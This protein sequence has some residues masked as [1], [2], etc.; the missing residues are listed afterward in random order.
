MSWDLFSELFL[1]GFFILFDANLRSKQ[2]ILLASH[3]HLVPTTFSA[4]LLLVSKYYLITYYEDTFKKSSVL[5]TF[6]AQ[7]IISEL[8]GTK[9]PCNCAHY[10]VDGLL[11]KDSAEAGAG[12]LRT[13][14]NC[15]CLR[16]AD[17]HRKT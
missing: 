16:R 5:V 3:H 4:Y 1:G 15:C 9:Q 10:F 17:G 6:V 13:G 11:G 12:V 7:E 8:C 14:T 2:S